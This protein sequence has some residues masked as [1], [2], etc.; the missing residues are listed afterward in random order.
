MPVRSPSPPTRSPSHRGPSALSQT[1]QVRGKL[2]AEDLEQGHEAL[3]RHEAERVRR[4]PRQQ[5]RGPA[6]PGHQIKGERCL[7]IT[8]EIGP[9]CVSA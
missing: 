2:E 1:S 3:A 4:R 7:P 6:M 9:V 8:I 5:R